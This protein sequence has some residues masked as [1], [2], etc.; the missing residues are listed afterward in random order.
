MVVAPSRPA[1]EDRGEE[2]KH[3]PCRGAPQGARRETPGVGDVNGQR[4]YE[5][6]S[7]GCGEH[8][9]FTGGGASRG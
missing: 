9:G 7:G 4:G 1:G 3:Y 2:E 6:D 8:R 5:A